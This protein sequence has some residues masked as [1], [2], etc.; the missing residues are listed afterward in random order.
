MNSVPSHDELEWP[1]LEPSYDDF[2]AAVRR[3]MKLCKQ[4]K[5]HNMMAPNSRVFSMTEKFTLPAAL[6]FTPKNLKT[7]GKNAGTMSNQVMTAATALVW[8]SS[9]PAGIE[10][11]WAGVLKCGVS[12]SGIL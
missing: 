10:R 11:A 1:K 5:E 7:T 4:V 3:R 2:L 6:R 12:K 9:Q 8:Y